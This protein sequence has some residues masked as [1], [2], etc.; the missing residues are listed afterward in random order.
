[1]KDVLETLARWRSEGERVALATV[2]S[3]Q[4][5]APREEGAT[6]LISAGG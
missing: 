3:V 5:S 4:G 2:I 1:M 6:M